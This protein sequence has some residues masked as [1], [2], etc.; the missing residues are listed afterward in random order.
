MFFFSYTFCIAQQMT[1]ST[2]RDLSI[3]YIEI[4][5]SNYDFSYPILS[6]ILDSINFNPPDDGVYLVAGYGHRYLSSTVNKSDNHGGFD[7]WPNHVYNGITYDANN[8]VDIICM[9]DGIISQVL[10]G[11]DS[12][13]NLTATGRSVQVLCDSSSQVFG[14]EIKINYRHL[15]AL[16]TLA[17]IADTATNT[18]FINKGDIIGKIGN[19]GTTN[20]VHLHLSTQTTQHPLYGNAFVNTARLFDPTKHPGVLEPLSDARI[21]IL[22]DWQD[23]T[24]FRITWP[25]NQSLNQVEFTNQSDTIVFNKEEAY[26]TGSSIR[27]NHDCIPNVSVFAYQFNGK[28]TASTRYLNA[29]NNMPAVYPAAPQRDTN[30]LLHGYLHLPITYDSVAY[31][32]DFVLKNLSPNHIKEDFVVKV[33]DVWGY[34]VEGN[35]SSPLYIVKN[36]LVSTIKYFPNPTEGSVQL[37]FKEESLKRIQVLNLSGQLLFQTQTNQ[38]R[39]KIDL[40]TFPTGIYLFQI[41]SEDTVENIKIIKK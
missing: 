32:Y 2:Y 1:T 7:F 18:V 15:S 12:V 35:L 6:D 40:S 4:N 31:V 39:K 29:M 10:N 38:N 5:P 16:G 14:T 34:T 27:D 22:H 33:S 25:F 26:D 28:L 11:P 20:N 13:L 19:S 23:S 17:T 37:I 21:E 41:A 9:C 3:P 30:L 8:K 24:L 36:N